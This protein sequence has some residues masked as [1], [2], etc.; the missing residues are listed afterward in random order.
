MIATAQGPT[1]ARL[2]GDCVVLGLTAWGGFMALLAQAQE[3]FVKQRQW[4]SEQEFLDLIALVTML[5]GPQAVNALAVMGHRLAGWGGFAAALA[6]IVLPSFFVILSLWYGYSLLEA[7]PGVL[8]AVTVGVLPP[9]AVILGQAACNQARKAAPGRK[10]KALAAA[11]AV[12]LL[13]IPFW[14]AP[15]Y[16]LIV[17][18]LVSLFFWPAPQ[19]PVQLRSRRIEPL[20]LLLCV[21]PAGL[22]VFQLVPALLPE[23]LVAKVGLAFAGLSTTLF[24][25][26]MVMVPLLE[27]LIVDHLGWLNHSGFSAGLAASQL[28]PGPILGIATFTGMEVAGFAGALAATFGVYLPTALISVGVSGVADRL[29]GSRPFQHAMVGVRCAVVGLIAG[30]AVSLLMKLPSHG[31]SWQ[32]AVLVAAAYVVVWRL[33]QPPYVALPV[34]VVLAWLIL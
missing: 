15:V 13:L 16:V 25:G 23:A 12:L 21:A 1:K 6:G 32:A 28:T 10:E 29:R 4:I 2:F 31:L 9:L 8:H 19:Q 7:Y 3:R 27:G 18:A 34:G 17:G 20:A 33:R 11:S 22:A 30:A 5:P 24:G 14:A 26:G